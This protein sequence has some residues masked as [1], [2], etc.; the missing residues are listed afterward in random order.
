MKEFP[1]CVHLAA[2]EIGAWLA[3]LA[4]TQTA[5]SLGWVINF[6][7]SFCQSLPERR[8]FHCN[9]PE[10]SSEEELGE[11]KKR[12]LEDEQSEAEESD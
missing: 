9:M 7:P 6:P 10:S 4:G 5:M 8:E 1:S 2:W 3:L 12:K 11:A